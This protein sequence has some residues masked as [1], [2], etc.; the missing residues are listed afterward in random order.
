MVKAVVYRLAVVLE[1]DHLDQEGCHLR[2]EI[3]PAV[4]QEQSACLL[5]MEYRV[6]A[7]ISRQL[8]GHR[9]YHLEARYLYLAEPEQLHR[10]ANLLLQPQLVELVVQVA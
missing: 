1:Q 6:L 10:A 4:P 7:V 3:Q 5:E 2:P 9:R 8:L